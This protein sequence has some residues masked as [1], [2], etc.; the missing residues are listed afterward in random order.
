M[1]N[2]FGKVSRLNICTKAEGGTTVI[3]DV[4]YTAPYKIMTPFPKASGGIRIIPLCA[5]AGIMEGDSQ[6]FTF[7][8]GEG[9]E[10]ELLSQSFDKI[11]KM[12][13]GE[14]V[15]R[16]SA[17]VEK[18]A[19][20]YYYPQPVIPFADS[21]FSSTMDIQLE[22]ETSRFFLMEIIS[23]G[24]S[25]SEERFQYRKY[26]SK[27]HIFRGGELVYRDNTRYVPAKMPMEGMGMYEGYT[28]MANIFLS[29]GTEEMKEEI[30]QILEAE[31][32][33][34]GGVTRLAMGDLAVR[35]LGRRAQVLQETA[36]KIKSLYEK[37]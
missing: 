37:K 27:V 1:N 9:S 8:V 20:F 34:E 6:E 2:Q 24:R 5:S 23:C 30:W 32:Q 36:E 17:R 16:I 26:D 31:V 28:H 22:D 35:I 33:C 21:A 4:S 29:G 19:A 3:S 12:K 11:H 15:R 25:A 10:L 13:E 14:A 7:S 18:N